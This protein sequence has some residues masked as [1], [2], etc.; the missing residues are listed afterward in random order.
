MAG[1][2]GLYLDANA[3]APQT[4]REV[5]AIVTGGGARYVDGGIIGPPPAAQGT[6]RLYLSGAARRA[7]GRSSRAARSKRGSRAADPFS[8]SAVKMAYAGWTKGSAA[9]LLAVRALAEAEGVGDVLAAEW[10]LSQ[11]GLEAR[12]LGAG[13]SAADK[14][15]RWTAEMD[16]D[17]RRHERRRAS[18]QGSDRARPR[19]SAG[20]P[21]PFQDRLAEPTKRGPEPS[22][23]RA[24]R[25][26]LEHEQHRVSSSRAAWRSR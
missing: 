8:A 24:P 26:S 10:A 12:L 5:A 22:N 25:A 20:T 2:D 3:I 19:S 23:K 15:W 1:F 14:G 17:R 16:G 6:T 21:A 7:C 9:L 13:R 11:P 18:Q 4:A